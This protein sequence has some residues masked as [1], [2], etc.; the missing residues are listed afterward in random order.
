MNID[1]E[2]L[3]DKAQDFLT[4]HNELSSDIK[5]TIFKFLQERK[6]MYVDDLIYT[7]YTENGYK[8]S[9]DLT[10]QLAGIVED[11]R[12]LQMKTTFINEEY[13]IEYDKRPIVV[14]IQ[15]EK[16]KGVNLFKIAHPDQNELSPEIQLIEVY[17]RLYD[18]LHANNWGELL[19]LEKKLLEDVK[20]R[21]ERKVIGG[22]E[23]KSKLLELFNALKISSLSWINNTNI[24]LI[25]DLA[26]QLISWGLFGT[27]II[28]M[29]DKVQVIGNLATIEE[30]LKR[31][32][33][34]HSRFTYST[35]KQD[36]HL[37][38][39]RRLFKTTFYITAPCDDGLFEKPFLD[40]FNSTDFELIPHLTS[41]RFQKKKDKNFPKLIK[42]GN[43]FVLCR[44]TF[45]DL[46]IIRIIK[47][48]GL[49][50]Q[51]YYDKVLVGIMERITKIKSTKYELI[52]RIFGTNYEGNWISEISAKKI[53]MDKNK[54]LWPYSPYWSK[55]IDR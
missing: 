22:G 35:R 31:F 14:I 28:N 44:F 46:W 24:I 3:F 38:G 2:K 43:P 36:L 16:Y 32:L 4:I 27:Q 40:V 5:N 13:M 55:K 20:S 51:N 19:K 18:P 7:L 34:T 23:C 37:I 1:V 41:G 52:N 29:T 53:E 6:L 33:E 30:L 50:D 45:I 39:D 8:D 25:G 42:I 9:K 49:V 47:H 21:Y 54:K 11:P 10:D 15:I 12:F 48:L 17:H 26:L